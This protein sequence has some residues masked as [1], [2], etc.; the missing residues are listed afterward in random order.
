MKKRP[1]LFHLILFDLLALLVLTE[2]K[3]NNLF[4]I[5]VV[6]LFV[7]LVYYQ[8]NIDSNLH[9]FSKKKYRKLYVLEKVTSIN[10]V[11][12]CLILVISYFSDFTANKY[13][14]LITG[15][16]AII[17]LVLGSEYLK[18]ADML[19]N[20]MDDEVLEEIQENALASSNN[21]VILPYYLLLS[22]LL[23]ASYYF[24]YISLIVVSLIF[25][26]SITTI[27]FFFGG[28]KNAKKSIR[29]EKKY[30]YDS[31]NLPMQ[32]TEPTT[33]SILVFLSMIILFVVLYFV[34]RLEYLSN[35]VIVAVI[36]LHAMYFNEFGIV[37]SYY[38]LEEDREKLE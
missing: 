36:S 4:M 11:A 6:L 18:V 1:Y 9:D 19:Y 35:L 16:F 13:L 33:Y 22:L 32:I 21:Y 38:L 28:P 34:H 10:V 25:I 7:N 8:Y 23:G 27:P 29:R 3:I 24:E 30:V 15:S 5:L 31:L 20:R 37:V 2:N 17:H 26:L 14:V 12:T